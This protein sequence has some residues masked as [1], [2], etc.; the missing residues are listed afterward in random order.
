M[1]A[2]WQQQQVSGDSLSERFCHRLQHAQARA[3]SEQQGPLCSRMPRQ[4]RCRVPAPPGQDDLHR[5]PLLLHRAP[6][7][8][9]HI[10]QA[11]DLGNGRHLDRHVHHVQ[12]RRRQLR[13]RMRQQGFFQGLWRRPA[14]YSCYMASV[15][16]TRPMLARLAR[17]VT[18]VGERAVRRWASYEEQANKKPCMGD[19]YAAH[20]SS[21]NEACRHA[22]RVARDPG[23]LLSG[24]AAHTWEPSTGR[25]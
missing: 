3:P 8:G 4:G 19:C 12:P 16:T 24:A 11:A 21:A 5:V 13:A 1:Q 23:S 22:G 20:C 14:M 7:R 10:A 25:L 18:L 9:H 6:Q 15:S 17:P 2:P